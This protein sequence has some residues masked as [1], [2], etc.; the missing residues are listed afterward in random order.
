[1]LN[2]FANNPS[3]VLCYGDSLTW[4]HLSDGIR[5]PLKDRWTF[6]LQQKLGDKF[7]VIEEGLRSRTTNIDDSDRADRDGFPY[8]RACFESHEPVKY[9]IYFLGTNDTKMKFN[10]SAVEICSATEEVLTWS[11]RHAE[12]SNFTTKIILISPPLINLVHLKYTSCFDKQS[13]SKLISLADE[14]QKLSAKNNYQFLDLSKIMQGAKNDGVHLNIED[15]EKISQLVA[16]QIL[17]QKI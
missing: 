11:K 15:N 4:G 14:Y 16:E 6:R 12:I 2:Q 5:Y 7:Y 13:N 1:M 17:R 8:F 10:R 9:L 3:T